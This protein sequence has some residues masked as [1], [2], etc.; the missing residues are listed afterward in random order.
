MNVRDILRE[1]LEAHGYEGLRHDECGCTVDDLMLC[2]EPCTTCE[3]GYR[4]SD[5]SGEYD[6]LIYLSRDAAEAKEA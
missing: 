5:P 3:P 1:W 2:D 4:G 6:W